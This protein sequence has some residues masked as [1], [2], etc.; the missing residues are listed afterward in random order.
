MRLAEP[1][2]LIAELTA[3]AG[4]LTTQVERLSARMEELERQARKDSTS[5]RLPTARIRRKAATGHCASA[6]NGGRE[7]SQASRG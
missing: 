4:Q 6:G 1:Y 7:G 5:L 2:R 3:Q